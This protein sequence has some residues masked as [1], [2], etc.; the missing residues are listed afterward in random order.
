MPAAVRA[1]AVIRL[2]IAMSSIV[3]RLSVDVSIESISR[4]TPDGLARS[5]RDNVRIA[6]TTA[7][8]GGF[9]P[10]APEKFVAVHLV[11]NPQ[12]GLVTRWPRDGGGRF[13][14][15]IVADQSTPPQGWP[16]LVIGRA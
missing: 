13:R 3:M 7:P 1:R 16:C 15:V 9:P 5:M 10:R 11:P 2:V 4:Q 8:V 14:P 6:N 12:R